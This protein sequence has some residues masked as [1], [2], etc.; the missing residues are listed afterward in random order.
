MLFR[1]P[2]FIKGRLYNKYSKE[3]PAK[4]LGFAS[5]LMLWKIT[6]LHCWS[7]VI[8]LIFKLFYF[9]LHFYFFNLFL[10]LQKYSV[11]SSDL[12]VFFSFCFFNTKINMFERRMLLD[13]K[14]NIDNK[15]KYM[16]MRDIGTKR[17][18]YYL[19]IYLVFYQVI[20]T[21]LLY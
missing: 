3:S 13:K 12:S 20:L 18:R 1:I 19:E 17:V 2:L 10:M 5:Y 11:F 14:F 15:V 9:Y 4:F 16:F 7:N 6:F 8:F 21:T